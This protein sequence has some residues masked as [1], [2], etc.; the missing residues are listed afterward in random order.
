MKTYNPK[1]LASLAGITVRTL[2]H[3][4]EIGLLKPSH[5]TESD[6]RVYKE[7]D[8]LRLQQIL[9]YKELE[10]PLNEIKEILDN[11]NFNLESALE[12]HKKLLL[13]KSEKYK[14]LVKT[15][16]KTI[17]KVKNNNELVT[18]K[19]LYEGFTKE[20]AEQYRKEAIQNWGEQKVNEVDK[21]IRSFTKQKWT[22]VKKE[23]TDI[24]IALAKLKDK[25]PSDPE[26]QKTVAQHHQNIEN[27]YEAPKDVYKG[28]ADL[29]IR[30]ERFKHFYDKHQKGLAE[31][32]NKA[33][34]IFADNNL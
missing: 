33:M 28:L 27:F 29:Y 19:E 12:D 24:A 8:L 20:E 13:E 9:L 3:Y 26:V 14:I 18:D 4:D 31:F 30:D 5:R 1:D 2:H 10:L 34:I 16:D 21:R 6:Y 25:D 22:N 11:P 15:I 17:D 23:Q 32:L 7:K